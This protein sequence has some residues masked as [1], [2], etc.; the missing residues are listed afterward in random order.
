MELPYPNDVSE[1]DWGT[2]QS[3]ERASESQYLEFKQSIS[4]GEG[5]DESEWRN[6]IEKNCSIR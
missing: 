2:I 5:D 6:K 3:L 4:A 1:W